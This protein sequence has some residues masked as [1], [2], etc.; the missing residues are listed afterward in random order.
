M[1][2]VRSQLRQVCALV[3]RDENCQDLCGEVKQVMGESSLQASL[4]NRVAGTENGELKLGMRRVRCPTKEADGAP[5]Q[6]S[7]MPQSFP[8]SARRGEQL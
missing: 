1:T 2:G 7:E 6:E 5:S 8:E 4:R 3:A